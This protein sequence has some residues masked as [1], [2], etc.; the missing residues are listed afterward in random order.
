ML[1]DHRQL[2]YDERDNVM[3]DEWGQIVF[4]I[5]EIITPSILALFKHKKEYMIVYGKKYNHPIEL[6]YPCKDLPYYD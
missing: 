6:I 2:Y 5:F 4:N 1:D 3:I